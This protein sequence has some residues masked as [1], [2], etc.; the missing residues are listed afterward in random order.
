[1]NSRQMCMFSSAFCCLYI[2][3]DFLELE[4]KRLCG[5]DMSAPV[6]KLCLLL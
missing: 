5:Q 6:F 2:I 4:S 1:M 3:C